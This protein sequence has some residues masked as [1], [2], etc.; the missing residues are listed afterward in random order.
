MIHN[1]YIFFP[2]NTW[3]HTFWLLFFWLKISVTWRQNHSKN[4]TKRNMNI[5]KIRYKRKKKKGKERERG[6]D[7]Y[8]VR[9]IWSK[10]KKRFGRLIKPL[11]G[12]LV[13]TK[14]DLLLPLFYSLWTKCL[15]TSLFLMRAKHECT[16]TLLYISPTSH[17]ST[18]STHPSFIRPFFPL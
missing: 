15:S 4:S 18:I 14:L 17:G 9:K 8:E 2:N 5:R 16:C 6:A 1:L 12:W 10:T 7:K 11:L 13:D 3:K